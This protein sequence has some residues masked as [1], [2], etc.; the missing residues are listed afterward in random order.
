M[1]AK[2]IQQHIESVSKINNLPSVLSVCLFID[3]EHEVY[4]QLGLCIFGCWHD[5]ALIASLDL[6]AAFKF[7]SHF[8]AQPPVCS[9][10]CE[11]LA[12]N[13]FAHT[14][15]HPE[16]L[17]WSPRTT[18]ADM[19]FPRLYVFSWDFSIQWIHHQLDIVTCIIIHFFTFKNIRVA[20]TIYSGQC[21][22]RPATAGQLGFVLW[23]ES[24]ALYL[25]FTIRLEYFVFSQ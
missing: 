18:R 1:A 12:F 4:W 3:L 23:A 13:R 9:S 6:N 10:S 21:L 14:L 16:T 7:H 24:V 19:L 8:S 17:V 20:L 11:M 25:R 22:C 15:R 2:G 5:L